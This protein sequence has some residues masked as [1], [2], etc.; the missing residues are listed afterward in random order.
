MNLSIDQ[1]I[2]ICED[3]IHTIDIVRVVSTSMEP[4]KAVRALSFRRAYLRDIRLL[5]E[6][7]CP[8]S[9]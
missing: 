7:Q 6:E 4:E 2:A 5:L 1:L 8:S 3:L 9:S